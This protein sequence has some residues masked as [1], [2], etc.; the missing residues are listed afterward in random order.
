M[1]AIPLDDNMR[2][3]NPFTLKR[4]TILVTG[5]SSGIGKAA[6]IECSRAGASVILTARNED[7]LKETHSLLYDADNQPE[8]IVADM[9]NDD[10]IERLVD[11]IP[12]IDGLVNNAGISINVPIAFIDR[13]KIQQVLDVNT[14]APILLTRLLVRKK[15]INKGGSIVFTASVSGNNTVTVAH[16]MYSASKTAI[17]GFMRNAALD[18]AVKGI[19]CN[20]V[21]PGM[22]NTPMVHSGKYSE[23]QLVKDMENYPL[24]RFGEP[25]EVA[26]AMI[27]LLSDAAAW[28][29]GHSLVI[30]GGLTLK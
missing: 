22:I 7:R 17:T 13:K 27:Y 8:W 29:T 26:Y 20:A 9:Q 19:R 24:R 14:I 4:K 10:D 25:E 23:E 18:L 28:V 16:E 12:K 1:E 2:D 3:Y 30:D 5:A 11:S 15:K 21:H 6:A